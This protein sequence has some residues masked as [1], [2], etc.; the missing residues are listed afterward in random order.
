MDHVAILAAEPR[1]VG[2]PANEAAE[3][4]IVEQLDLLGWVVS[5]QTTTPD[6]FRR[7]S[8]VE[9]T[10]VVGTNTGAS[11]TGSIILIAHYDSDPK[12]P[13]ANDNAAAVAALLETARALSAD[14]DVANDVTLLFTDAEEPAGRFG[15]NAFLADQSLA[16]DAA[17]FV[18]FEALGGSGPVL[19]AEVSGPIDWLIAEMAAAG[20]RPLAFSALTATTELMGEIGTDFDPFSSADIPG[21]HFAYLR[22]SPIYHTAADNT[23]AVSLDSLQH[24]GSLALGIARHFGDLDLTEATSVG[25]EVDFFPVGPWF[26]H[27][28]ATVTLIGLVVA[29]LG[30]ATLLAIRRKS[31]LPVTRALAVGAR[32]GGLLLATTTAATLVWILIGKA[33]PSVGVME[34]YAYLALIV[35]GLV[36]GGIALRHR[37]PSVANPP[38]TVGLWLVFAVLTAAVAPGAAYTFVWPTLAATALLLADAAG[39]RVLPMVRLALVAAPAIL[40]TVPM[41]DTFFLLAQPRPGN[42]DSEMLFAAVVP[43]LV[44]LMVGM[45]VAAFWPKALRPAG[46]GLVDQPAPLPTHMAANSSLVSSRSS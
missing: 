46:Q 45:L 15:A 12:T 44:A 38:A 36:F 24:H 7:G 23:D 10:N 4:Y 31:G 37:W 27:Y 20:A 1:P 13:G 26:V 16:A 33:R 42:L 25:R 9:L 5:T 19:L 43:I 34:S 6:I 40:L 21:F 32:L 41:I 29:A 3:R 39:R 28:P 14:R 35:G 11:S 30:L 18:N 2:S 8:P 17:L 22:G